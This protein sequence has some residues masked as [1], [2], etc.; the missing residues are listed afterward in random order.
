MFIYYHL[1]YKQ[2]VN[3]RMIASVKGTDHHIAEDE[4]MIRNYERQLLNKIAAPPGGD[5]ALEEIV[6]NRRELISRESLNDEKDE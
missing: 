2:L 1:S 3:R 6:K 5:N 4:R